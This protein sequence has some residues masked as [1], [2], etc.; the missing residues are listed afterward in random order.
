MDICIWVSRAYSLLISSSFHIF[1]HVKWTNGSHS[2]CSLAKHT[3]IHTYVNINAAKQCALCAHRAHFTLQSR[4]FYFVQFV[5]LAKVFTDIWRIPFIRSFVCCFV[6][7][8]FHLLCRF[9]GPRAVWQREKSFIELWIVRNVPNERVRDKRKI[10]VK[11]MS[12]K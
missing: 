1:I 4:W 6:R 5:S 7:D 11:R 3:C 8:S 9:L 2:L 12:N 10:E